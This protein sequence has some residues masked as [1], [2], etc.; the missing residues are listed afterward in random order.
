[1]IQVLSDLNQLDTLDKAQD[2][3]AKHFKW[4]ADDDNVV[5]FMT[6]LQ[7]RYTN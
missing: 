2:Y 1:M 3:L 5:D 7:R 4:V 6:L